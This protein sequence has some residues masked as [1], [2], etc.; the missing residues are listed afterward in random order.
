MPANVS[1]SLTCTS[2]ATIDVSFQSPSPMRKSSRLMTKAPLAVVFA[3]VCAS[4]TGTTRSRLKPFSASL[5]LTSNRPAP[6][7]LTVV[8]WNVACGNSLVLNQ[9]GLAISAS[10]SAVPMATLARSIAS[11][12][13]AVSGC[14]G[15]NATCASKRLNLPSTGTPIWRVV[16]ASSLCAGSSFCCAKAGIAI[17]TSAAR[18]MVLMGDVIVASSGVARPHACQQRVAVDV[19]VLEC[20]HGVR[21]DQDRHAPGKAL[22]PRLN[23]FG[24]QLVNRNEVGQRQHAEHDDRKPRRRAVGPA[25]QRHGEEQ[26]VQQVVRRARGE[27]LPARHRH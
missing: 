12:I 11:A 7:G 22:V 2:L 8:D 24:E 21:R 1:L 3:P 17:A 5:P 16:N 18:V 9:S 4:V 25:G 15:S 26:E 6:S 14:F 10:V 20:G 19:V 13:F 27:A 23:G